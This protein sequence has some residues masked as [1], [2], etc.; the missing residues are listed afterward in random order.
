MSI[1]FAYVCAW[2]TVYLLVHYTEMGASIGRV[3][4]RHEELSAITAVQVLSSILFVICVEI[5]KIF[6]SVRLYSQSAIAEFC[7]LPV[8]TRLLLRYLPTAILY[9][10]YNNLMLLNL[11]S[12]AP[13][14]YLIIT[15][16]KLVITAV[17]WKVNFE[18]GDVT[19]LRK[20]AIAIITLGI[21][22]RAISGQKGTS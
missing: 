20:L 21:F 17:A 15:S 13:T 4:Q 22:I 14:A 3:Q 2:V 9:T 11:R 8:V 7:E 12:N 6:M 19:P 16:S 10:T 1:M 18:G 5:I